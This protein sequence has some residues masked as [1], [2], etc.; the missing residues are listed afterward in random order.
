[1]ED[2]DSWGDTAGLDARSVPAAFRVAP[3]L[4]EERNVLRIP[5]RPVAC[6]RLAM[7][8]FDLESSFIKPTFRREF[9][10]LVDLL[11]PNPQ[12][13]VSVF[14]HADPAGTD[15]FNKPLSARRARAVYALLVRDAEAWETLH[16]S[17]YHN[18]DWGNRSIQVMLQTLVNPRSAEERAERGELPPAFSETVIAMNPPLGYYLGPTD[19]ILGPVTLAAVRSFQEDHGLA[20]D[21]IVGPATRAKLF[22]A[23]MDCL[24]S[25]ETGQPFVLPREAFLDRGA[26]SDGRMAY[27][28]CSEL[29]PLRVLDSATAD[30]RAARERKNAVNRRVLVLLFEHSPLLGPES[31]PCPAAHESTTRCQAHLWADGD[32]RRAPGPQE[33]SRRLREK[34]FACRF[35]DELT[36]FSPCE[37]VEKH[38]LG[39]RLYDDDEDPNPLPGAPYRLTLGG[40]VITGIASSSWVE[41]RVSGRPNDCLLEWGLPDDPPLGSQGGEP[42]FSRV[43]HL[44]LEDGDPE[45]AHRRRLHNLGYPD[46]APL[47]GNLRTFQ[48]HYGLPSTEELDART[49]AELERIHDEVIAEGTATAGSGEEDSDVRVD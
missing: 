16:Q 34:T 9:L 44:S 20:A 47:S 10:R 35:Y 26:S 40:Q 21:G 22:R 46:T 41:A 33:R 15:D 1:M 39:I 11:K 45:T 17:P 30:D 4:G 7:D 36:H 24:C 42:R 13:L 25:D 27:Q 37:G 43:V 8:H 23:Y 31:W 18:D 2:E 14:G 28:G 38:E 29:N 32:Q 5:L 49:R 12:A 3:S 19:G 6:W 48:D